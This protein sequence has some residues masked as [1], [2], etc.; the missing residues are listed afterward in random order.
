VLLPASLSLEDGALVEPL[1]VA[2][3]GVKRA[4][5]GPG[6]HVLVLGAGPVGL[7]AIFWARRLG[8]GRIG[9]VEPSP[10]RAEI[11][12]AMGAD[13]AAPA[14]TD[15][16][17]LDD[18]AEGG[19]ADPAKPDIVIECTGVPGLIGQA[20]KRVRPRGRV[21]VL[22]FCTASDQ[23]IPAIANMKEVAIDFA[24]A[25]SLDDFEVSARAL[26]AGAVAPRAM[27][28]DTVSLAQFPAAFEALR[29]APTQCKVLVDPWRP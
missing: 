4:G 23:I 8:A 27:I 21:L 6:S 14:G 10:R 3:H 15:A 5:I 2:V 19:W 11:A 7:A 17:S 25:W 16:L 28:T 22:G 29:T 12:R 24:V 1:A 9:I 26:D 18:L 20:I 13:Y